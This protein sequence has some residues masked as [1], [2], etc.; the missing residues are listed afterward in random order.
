M[1]DMSRKLAIFKS[2]ID[3]S[4]GQEVKFSLAN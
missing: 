4:A 2:G 3:I 1:V